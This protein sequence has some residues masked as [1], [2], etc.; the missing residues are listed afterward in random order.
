M[1]IMRKKMATK[2]MIIEGC[3]SPTHSR[4]SSF[5]EDEDDKYPDEADDGDNKNAHSDNYAGHWVTPSSKP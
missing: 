2:V 4:I 1:L 3:R 5:Y